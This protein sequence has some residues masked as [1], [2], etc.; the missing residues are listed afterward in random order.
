[1]SIRPA[2]GSLP[3]SSLQS[4]SSLVIQQTRNYA[5]VIPWV[6]QMNRYA[7]NTR[8]GQRLLSIE[9]TSHKFKNILTRQS[10][11]FWLHA[12]TPTEKM[13]LEF[14]V[15]FRF[16]YREVLVADEQDRLLGS[17]RQEFFALRRKFRV[18]G[19]EGQEL[20]RIVGRMWLDYDQWDYAIFQYRTKIGMISNEWGGLAQ[21]MLTDA[22]TYTLTFPP[23]LPLTHKYL[24]IG[25]TLLIDL[26][27]FEES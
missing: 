7:V 23:N 3:E 12:S 2:T 22:D 11:P 6:E 18:Y 17:I 10:P 13:M 5:E 15:P 19:A 9:D 24:L 21:E 25:A 1:M 8:S 26:I 27:Y 16:L 4:A 20:Y 14:H